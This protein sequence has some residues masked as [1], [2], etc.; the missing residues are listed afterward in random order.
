MRTKQITEFGLLLA[1]SLVLAY[2]E[3][4][5][6]VLVAIP[7]VKIGLANIVTLLILYRTGSWNTLF[8]MTL[9]VVL[10][11][12][13]FSG[14]AGILYSFAGGAACILVMS[15]LKRFSFFSTIGVSMAGAIFHNFGQLAVAVIVMENLY[16]LYYFPIL[17]L[18]GILSGFVVGYLSYLLFQQ[19]NKIFP[20]D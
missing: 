5:I 2:L 13:L 3:N 6:P 7:G 4:L 17:C 11:G 8:F 10:S 19:Y 14:I 18:S 12:F 1:V 15:I 16:I 9:R 20:S